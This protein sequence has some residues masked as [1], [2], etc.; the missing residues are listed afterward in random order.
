MKMASSVPR[1]LENRNLKN[2]FMF[3]VYWFI[4]R[5][6]YKIYQF[7]LKVKWTDAYP[8]GLVT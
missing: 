7:D 2:S 3:L 5:A 4:I 8:H 6:I 1:K